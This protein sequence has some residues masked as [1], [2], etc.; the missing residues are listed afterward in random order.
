MKRTLFVTAALALGLAVALPVA[1][2]QFGHGPMGSGMMGQGPMGHGMKG[3]GMHHAHGGWGPGGAARFERM[4]EDQDARLAGMLAFAKEKLDIT[5]QQ[6]T[7]WTKFTEAAR[8][9]Q[10]PMEQAC[11]TLKDQ[12]QPTTLPERLE[13][14]QTV[15][16]ARA[17]QLEQM[18]PA[19]KELYGQLTPEQQKTADSIMQRGRR[20]FF[21]PQGGPQN[22]PQGAPQNDQRG[23]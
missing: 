12:A 4:C 19:V 18:V 21:G 2:Q 1:A 6:E 22:G 7:A 20:G 23:G 9:S 5:A 8:A 16:T 14:M 10:Q 13:R 15:M 11:A 17:T 3:W